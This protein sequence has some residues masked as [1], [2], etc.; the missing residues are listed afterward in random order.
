M[1]NLVKPKTIRKRDE[2]NKT[3]GISLSVD[4]DTDKVQLKLR[5]NA[6]HTEALADEL[7]AIDNTWS[8]DCGSLD[9][10]DHT[11]PSGSLVTRVCDMCK[12]S[13]IIPNEELPTRLEGSD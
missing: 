3:K 4:M 2:M 10:S 8:C 6:K 12:E 9:Y 1:F 13:Y 5:A 7:D 11:Y